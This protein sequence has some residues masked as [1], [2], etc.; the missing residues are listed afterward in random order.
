[1]ERKSLGQKFLCANEE[2]ILITFNKKYDNCLQMKRSVKDAKI[3]ER[4]QMRAIGGN[5]TDKKDSQTTVAKKV[6]ST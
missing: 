6:T 5:E 2:Y 1:M 3:S 4:N